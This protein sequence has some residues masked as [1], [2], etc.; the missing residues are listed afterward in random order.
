MRKKVDKGKHI[1]KLEY[2]SDPILFSKAMADETRQKIMQHLCCNWLCVSDI[3][4]K[5]DGDVSQPTVSHHLKILNDAGLL[6]RRREGKQIYN[7]LNQEMVSIC[8]GQ[9]MAHFAPEWS[10]SS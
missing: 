5:L 4:A 2:M 8:C 6:H 7:S 1:D 9:L 10:A 3:V